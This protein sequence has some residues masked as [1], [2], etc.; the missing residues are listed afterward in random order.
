MG[1]YAIVNLLEFD[2]DTQGRFP[3]MEAVRAFEAGP[4]GLEVICVG[5]HRPKGG[6]SERFDDFW[7]AGSTAR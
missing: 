1:D 4:D 7:P 6:D 5:G 2:D 3:G